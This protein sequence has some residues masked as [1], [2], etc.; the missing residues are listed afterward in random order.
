MF[1]TVRVANGTHCTPVRNCAIAKH[2]ALVEEGHVFLVLACFIFI[3]RWAIDDV[4]HE[5]HQPLFLALITPLAMATLFV[6]RPFG[7]PVSR[8]GSLI[9]GEDFIEGHTRARWFTLKKRISRDRIKSISEN[10]RGLCV[11]DQ[12]EFAA[13]ML[14]FVFVPASMPE[15]QEIKSTLTRWAPMKQQG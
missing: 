1:K 15:Y 6:F 2:A 4:L 11:M 8:G 14:G 7:S 12:S 9:I 5:S 13:R 10:R 3:F